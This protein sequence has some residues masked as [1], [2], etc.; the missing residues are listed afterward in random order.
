M[1]ISGIAWWSRPVCAFFLDAAGLFVGRVELQ[2]RVGPELTIGE[3]R[4]DFPT[5][6][7]IGNVDEASDVA[8]VIGY[9]LFVGVEDIH[10]HSSNAV[11][12]GLHGQTKKQRCNLPR[13]INFS[14]IP[15]IGRA[16]DDQQS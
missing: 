14:S 3:R 8:G 11:A 4:I 9:D 13:S 10:I 2:E 1:K 16:S 5:D 6:G 7:G 15:A 12:D